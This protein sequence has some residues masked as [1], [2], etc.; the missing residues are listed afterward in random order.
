MSSLC[1]WLVERPGSAWLGGVIQLL[2][3]AMTTIPS[4]F[5]HSLGGVQTS[6]GPGDCEQGGADSRHPHKGGGG[7]PH[8]AQDEQQQSQE[9]KAA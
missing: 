2:R 1:P 9:G 8:Q 6:Q 7:R 5:Y 4:F 3:S